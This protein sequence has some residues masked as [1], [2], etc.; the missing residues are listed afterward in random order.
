VKTS[1]HPYLRVARPFAALLF[2]VVVSVLNVEASSRWATLEAI[3]KL[4]NP[5]NSPKPGRH[6][7]LG[8]YQFRSSTWRMHTAVPFQRAINRETSDIVAVK[9]Y[10]WIKRG[11]EAAR[12][13]ATPYNIALAWNGGLGAVISGRSPRVAHDY[14]QRAANLAAAYDQ[15]RPAP[16]P[17]PEIPPAATPVPPL[18]PPQLAP[19]STPLIAV[20]QEVPVAPVL[21]ALDFTSSAASQAAQ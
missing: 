14:A 20:N 11:L 9:H 12:V 4:E 1:T 10:E 2:V 21:L 18:F 5:R 7:E 16:E 19:A 8:A 3:H 13:P 6:G 15:N 17:A